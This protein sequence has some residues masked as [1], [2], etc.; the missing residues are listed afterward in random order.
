MTTINLHTEIKAPIKE[1][2]DLSRDI[3]FHIASASRTEEQAIDGTTRGLINLNETVTWRGKHF[4]FWL[5]HTSKIIKLEAPNKFTD[6][7]IK[8]HFT[9][10][11]HQHI[12]KQQGDTTY[13]EDILSYKVPFG[14]AGSLFDRLLLKNHLIQFLM[15]RNRALKFRLEENDSNT[16]IQS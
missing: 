8:G 14:I 16:P 10:F 7:M 2:F 15:T 4:G 11:A 5:Q 9:Y 1:V 3:T 12:F 6:I 13:M